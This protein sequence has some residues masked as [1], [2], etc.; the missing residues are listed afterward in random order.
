MTVLTVLLLFMLLT[1]ARSGRDKKQD[2]VQREQVRIRSIFVSYAFFSE[3]LKM[4]AASQL[5]V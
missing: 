4:T 5:Q 2:S 1:S 3:F